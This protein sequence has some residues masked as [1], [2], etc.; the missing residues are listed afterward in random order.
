MKSPLFRKFFRR[1]LDDSL[2]KVRQKGHERLTIM[3]IPHSK[4]DVFSLQLNWSMIIFLFGTVLLAA[5]LSVYGFYWNVTQSREI[6]RL[7]DLY[8]QNL[9]SAL[10]VQ[11]AAEGNRELKEK[12][13]TRLRDLS[14]LVGVSKSALQH[15]PEP[16][17]AEQNA[18]TYL[19]TEVQDR[20]DMGPSTDYLPP[21]YSLRTLHLMFQQQKPLL[22]TLSSGIKDGLGVYRGMPLGRPLRLT[23]QLIDTSFYGIRANP[24]RLSEHEF[25]SGM[26][27]STPHGTPVY[28]TANGTVHQA[29]YSSTGY[30][31]TIIIR[32]QNGYY[33][34]FA[35]LSAINVRKG[36]SVSRGQ[37]IGAV[38]K[39]GRTTGSHL[40]Y[41]IRMNNTLKKDPLPYVCSTDLDSKSCRAHNQRYKL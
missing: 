20:L 41:E 36:Q 40:H 2:S 28:A 29:S 10:A 12:L 25:H 19:S 38:G 34:L 7:K 22:V 16:D 31:N 21:I 37:R 14:L 33:S 1:K 18:R 6:T 9:R 27:M 23:S 5:M 24:T 13:I 32:H 4:E 15:L 39:T 35:H 17:A 3:L 8:G 11:S 26:D 30:G